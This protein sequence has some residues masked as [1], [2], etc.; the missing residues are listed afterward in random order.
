MV[1]KA[2]TWPSKL[3][4]ILAKVTKARFAAF[5]INSIHIKTTIAFLLTTTPTAPIVNKI[6]ERYK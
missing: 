3:P 2:T 1:K 4:L 5:S 6:A